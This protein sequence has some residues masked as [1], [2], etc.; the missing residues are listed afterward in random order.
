M[1]LFFFLPTKELTGGVVHGELENSP[2]RGG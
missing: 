1:L 2:V